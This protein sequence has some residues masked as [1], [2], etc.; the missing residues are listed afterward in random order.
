MSTYVDSVVHST[1]YDLSI[2]DLGSSSRGI[3]LWYPAINTT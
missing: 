1:D 2:D 3:D